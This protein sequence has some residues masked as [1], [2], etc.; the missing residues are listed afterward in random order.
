MGLD[1]V[2][3]TGF[4]YED[5]LKI[6]DGVATIRSDYCNGSACFRCERIC[7]EKVFH[8]EELFYIKGDEATQL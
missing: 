2:C 3:Y 1:V 6:N 8:Y 5:A 4:V 7:P